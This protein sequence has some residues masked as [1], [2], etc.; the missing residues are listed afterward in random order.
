MNLFFT[1]PVA[2]FVVCILVGG[3]IGPKSV[4]QNQTMEPLH[5]LLLGIDMIMILCI[6]N[7]GGLSFLQPLGGYAAAELLCLK[8]NRTGIY[9]Q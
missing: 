2:L 1:L 5:L 3:Q 8:G 6:T 9:E 7:F 4:G